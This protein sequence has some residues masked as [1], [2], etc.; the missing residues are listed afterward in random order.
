[1]PVY[2]DPDDLGKDP[3]EQAGVWLLL[4]SRVIEHA[5]LTAIYSTDTDGLPTDAGLREL[6]RAATVAQVA[7][8]QSLD[9]DPTRGEAGLTDEVRVST[10]SI[11]SASVSYDFRGMQDNVAARVAALNA[12]APEAAALL[13]SLPRGPVIVHG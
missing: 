4:A 9:I 5:T 11:G 3:P 2:A 1:M 7:Y 8:W 10:K 12:L 6:F 13:D